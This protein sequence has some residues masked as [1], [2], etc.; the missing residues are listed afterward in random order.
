[1]I[2]RC[3]QL[4]DQ[5]LVRLGGLLITILVLLIPF[6]T[7]YSSTF[8]VDDNR[9]LEDTSPGDGV[10]KTVYG[11]C[12]LRAAVMETNHLAGP[13]TIN[14]PAMTIYLNREFR[15]ADH[16]G[17]D[18]VHFVGAGRDKTIIDGN[19]STR[20]FYFSARSGSHSISNLTIRNAKNQRPTSEMHERNGGGVFNEAELKLT[21]VRVTNCTAFQ[22][23]GLFN[24]HDFGSDNVPTL[25][26]N[27]VILDHNKATSYEF[28]FGGGGLF[29]GS[30]LSGVDV[31]ITDNKANQQ[32][33]GYYNNSYKKAQLTDFEISRNTSMQA[34]GIDN[35]LGKTYL[36][37]GKIEANTTTCCIPGY[38]GTGGAGIFN[39]YGNMIIKNVD[40]SGN[41]SD[42]P[43]GFGGGIYNF[44]WMTL[45]NVS[46]T[47]NRATYG[48]GIDNGWASAGYENNLT[49]INVTISGNNGPARPDLD[50]EG[51]AIHNRAYGTINI[52]NSTIT[53]NSAECAGGI[54]NRNGQESIFIQNTI[55]AENSDDFGADDCRGSITSM[56]HNIIGNP[57]GSGAFPCTVQNISSSDLLQ[58]TPRFAS[59]QG[60]PA[61]HPLL[62]G[63]PAID[64]GTIENCPATDIRGI[65]RPAGNT[66]DIG[67]YEMEANP[68]VFL[69]TVVK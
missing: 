24:Q 55:L 61:F 10:C 21:N 2:M 60:E 32:G 4:S 50:T 68:P 9:D 56:G 31:K 7:T 44:K 18:S 25:T 67:A 22:G 15:I 30:V 46:I 57:T 53:N 35:D 41:V 69:P 6:Q 37:N 29:N 39:N 49:L 11:T 26:L 16:N 51:A 40:I 20:A 19:N 54:T 36:T 12:T 63:S 45:E 59:L 48:A 52:F 23:G 13:N 17:D 58:Q 42:S 34:G 65:L 28:G 38:L 33:G 27:N 62:Q 5:K 66:C 43:G 3:M 14:I 8:T 47:N 1:M 64:S